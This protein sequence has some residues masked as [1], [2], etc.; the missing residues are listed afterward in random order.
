M[1]QMMQVWSNSVDPHFPWN[2]Q[3]SLTMALKWQSFICYQLFT[4][5]W[6]SFP[7]DARSL[8]DFTYADEEMSLLMFESM[9]QVQ[10]QGM[11]GYI[12]FDENGDHNG[13]VKF[14]R[15][16]STNLI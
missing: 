7:G 8:E 2:P 15:N 10:F 4:L 14:A 6:T 11:K 13:M 12:F 16:Q 5:L 1:Q 9:K 3:F